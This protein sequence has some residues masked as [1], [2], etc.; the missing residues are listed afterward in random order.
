LSNMGTDA[1]GDA[2]DG[3]GKQKDERHQQ[4]NNHV[5]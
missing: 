1:D 4:S 5:R 3:K 2:A